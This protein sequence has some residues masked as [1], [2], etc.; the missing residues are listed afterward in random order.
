MAVHERSQA[1]GLSLREEIESCRACPRLVDWREQ[2][3]REKRAAFADQ[4]YWGRPV[5]RASATR[6]RASTS[7][8][9]RRPP[10]A[11]T[12]PGRVFTGDRSGD[13]LFAALFRAGLANQPQSFAQ[14]RRA[15]S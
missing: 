15:A 2:V 7:W 14:R 6:A 4:E 5:G 9:W 10:T 11:P 3:A 13:F 1:Q 8:A 12:A